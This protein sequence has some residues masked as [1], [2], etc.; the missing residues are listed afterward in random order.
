MR[1]LVAALLVFWESLRFAS[2]ALMVFSTIPYRGAAAA[3]ELVAHG[4]VAALTAAAGLALWNASPDARRL[5]T[6]AVIASVL[7]TVQSQYWS[8]LPN[9]TAPGD[10]PLIVGLTLVIG[11]IALV[12]IARM[13]DEAAAGRP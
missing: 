11:V 7:R 5:A 13:N 8:V 1:R 10:E 3:I 9:N 6:I 2:E 12:V 4:L